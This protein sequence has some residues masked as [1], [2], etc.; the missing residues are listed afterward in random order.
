MNLVPVD[1]DV[2]SNNAMDKLLSPD[3][4]KDIDVSVGIVANDRGEL[5]IAKRPA[6]WLGGGYWEFPGGKIEPNEDAQSALK[7]E[8]REEVGIEVQD[9]QPLI[10]L[11][12][13]YPERNVSLNAWRVTRYAG[14]AMGLE[15]QEIRW[16]TPSEL[17]HMNMLP[18][19]RAIVIATQLPQRYLI[20]PQCQDQTAFLSQLNGILKTGQIKLMQ[21][22][23]KQ[24]S[25][26]K[27]SELAHYTSE[28][29]RKYGVTFLVNT[30]DIEL[31]RTLDCDGIQLRSQQLQELQQRPLANDKWVSASCHNEQDIQKAEQLGLDFITV[32]PIKDKADS[33]VALGWTR[34]QQLVALA[35]I[36]VFALGGLTLADMPLAKRSGAQGIAAIRGFWG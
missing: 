15:G 27:Y 24:L 13:R 22:R 4:Y 30:D 23:S 1:L 14:E 17:D 9:Y 32:S 12:Y 36:P 26:I 33:Q 16:C 31:A 35:N 7:R 11:N 6:H 10:N 5:L 28:L 20:T 3:K 8:L 19:N 2:N 18:A 21:L 29:C 25:S 34:F